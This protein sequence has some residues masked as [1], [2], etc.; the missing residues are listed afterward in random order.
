M[1]SYLHFFTSKPKFWEIS[2]LTVG[3]HV[4]W[5]GT[6]IRSHKSWTPVLGLQNKAS[7]RLHLPELLQHVHSSG[8]PWPFEAKQQHDAL[9]LMGN[10]SCHIYRLQPVEK[11]AFICPPP[12]SR[13]WPFFNWLEINVL[14]ANMNICTNLLALLDQEVITAKMSL[15]GQ[16][17][18]VSK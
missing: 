5:E 14:T 7:N 17:E 11:K 10:S 2:I 12:A 1:S 6:A 18:P 8:G 4:P 3:C 15:S 13:P 16:G 9:S